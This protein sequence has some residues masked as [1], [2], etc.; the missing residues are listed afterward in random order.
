MS[1][2]IVL[3]ILRMFFLLGVVTIMAFRITF[4]FIHSF[5][6]LLT[7]F[8]NLVVEVFSVTCVVT[9]ILCFAFPQAILGAVHD[10]YYPIDCE[11][12]YSL[13][14]HESRARL[15]TQ[16]LQT[17]FLYMRYFVEHMIQHYI[18]ELFGPT[19]ASFFTPSDIS[20]EFRLFF[21]LSE[22]SFL[23][24]SSESITRVFD[25][26][27]T[28]NLI[29]EL[30]PGDFIKQQRNVG[31]AFGQ[32][33]MG[34]ISS[35]GD[36][37]KESLSEELICMGKFC[38]VEGDVHW[39]GPRCRL[40]VPDQQGN[41]QFYAD[42]EIKKNCPLLTSEQSLFVRNFIRQR[43][44]ADFRRADDSASM[45]YSTAFLHSYSK[46]FEHFYRIGFF[47]PIV[48]LFEV[49][50][51]EVLRSMWQSHD[52]PHDFLDEVSSKY[53]SRSAETTSAASAR[54]GAS[55]TRV[56]D[57]VRAEASQAESDQLFAEQS[58]DT[59]ISFRPLQAPKIGVRPNARTPNQ[60]KTSAEDKINFYRRCGGKWVIFGDVHKAS[61]LSFD[62]CQYF[63]GFHCICLS[64]LQMAIRALHSDHPPSARPFLFGTYEQGWKREWSWGE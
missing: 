29:R 37:C 53:S 28:T 18:F 42:L 36:V 15:L 11:D 10:C 52:V 45:C 43:E 26:G 5:Y 46:S 3:L 57:S 25:S 50:D 64:I 39:R 22:I 8:R 32:S 17:L 61:T 63:W 16:L 49:I 34:D 51:P 40:S 30:L 31:L 44:Q 60:S 24:C 54:G 4:R 2:N 59:H 35:F 13:S 14:T 56:A 27:A 1:I 41:Y 20:N 58:D 62:S 23:R 33:G 55:S 12:I 48:S 47:D 21:E 6:T 19:F 38:A 7:I 9:F